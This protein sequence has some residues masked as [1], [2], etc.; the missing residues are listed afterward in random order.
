MARQKQQFLRE[1]EEKDRYMKM[2]EEDR[3]RHLKEM[4][5]GEQREKEDEKQAKLAEERE[6]KRREREAAERVGALCCFFCSL[7]FLLVLYLIH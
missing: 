1:R 5:V 3:M 6:K 7:D 4:Q 2:R